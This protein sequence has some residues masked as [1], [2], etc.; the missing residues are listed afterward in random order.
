MRKLSKT[1]LIN[2]LLFWPLTAIFVLMA[3]RAYTIEAMLGEYTR[4][5]GCFIEW[6]FI[7]DAA[8]TAVICSLLWLSLKIH[9]RKGQIS[10]RIIALLVTL[11][12]LADVIA[13]KM[14]NVRLNT[15][16]VINY[17][18]PQSVLEFFLLDLRLLM[19]FFLTLLTNA[20]VLVFWRSS[21]DRLKHITAVAAVICWVTS[22]IP[23]EESYVHDVFYRN[24]VAVNL[25]H[26]SAKPYS[27]EYIAILDS[28]YPHSGCEI[29]KFSST[30]ER[31]NIILLVVESLSMY[32]SHLFSG[33]NNWTPNIDEIARSNRYF[34]NFHSNSF[35]SSHGLIAL[36]SGH[37][38]MVPIKPFLQQE[39][40]EGYVTVDFTTP[41][42]LSDAGYETA[43]LK[44]GTLSSSASDL[45]AQS[46]GFDLIEG[47]ENPIYEGEERYQFNSVED[48]VF[49]QRVVNY[50][51]SAPTP[52][53]VMAVTV[54][55]HL[56]FVVPK[57]RELN[58]E[59]TMRYVDS[60]VK[61]LHDDLAKARFFEDGILIIT[62]DH[63]A[64]TPISAE[65]T[66]LFG[67]SAA[68]LVPL[69]IVGGDFNPGE[70]IALT[71]QSDLLNSIVSLLDPAC[72]R[73][74]M[75]SVLRENPKA[76][77]CVFHSRGDRRDSINVFCGQES[78]TIKFAGDDTRV[79][80]GQLTDEKEVID[81]VNFRRILLT[82]RAQFESSDAETYNGAM[83]SDEI[84][85]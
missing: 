56:P 77:E 31:P 79:V 75:G 68:S 81:Y 38:T 72:E 83:F 25:D 74:Q 76:A 85:F 44:A 51:K 63:R 50:A 78:A 41:K 49:Y 32:H 62:S 24:F 13:I 37:P 1:I 60:A 34:T 17:L 18:E 28:K 66:S 53:F 36:A 52:Y 3:Y 10:L 48:L 23:I 43:F 35:R 5:Q 42:F 84:C 26:G 9:Q 4:C 46:M 16:D 58:Q 67:R 33:L 80:S 45:F 65:E 22:V 54:T 15:Y 8:I 30:K 29:C 69:I 40:L 27:S 12:Y 47:S 82:R 59:A 71:Q 21:H 61:A 11:L 19:L 73:P 64:M 14:F 39:Q 2:F 6:T 20:I 7:S 55:S 57:T 70:Q